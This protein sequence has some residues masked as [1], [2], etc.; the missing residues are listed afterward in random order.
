MLTQ[1]GG[2]LHDTLAYKVILQDYELKENNSYK[3]KIKIIIYD[4]FGLDEPVIK[5]KLPGN[6]DAF[7]A[8]FILQHVR[9]YIP[10]VTKIEFEHVYKDI[11]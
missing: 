1:G 5:D 10:F 2:T 3:A 7:R 11:F 6:I 8:W 9:G 4:H